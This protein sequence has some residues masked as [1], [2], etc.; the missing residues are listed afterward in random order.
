MSRQDKQ[1]RKW[2]FFE[3]NAAFMVKMEFENR[4]KRSV[5]V[6]YMEMFFLKYTLNER[7]QKSWFKNGFAYAK[8][9]KYA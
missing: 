4:Q 1:K 2:K 6:S 7:S 8:I 5:A 3:E 9:F